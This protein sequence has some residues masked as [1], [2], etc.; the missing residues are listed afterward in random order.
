MTNE[1]SKTIINNHIIDIDFFQKFSNKTTKL[2]NNENRDFSIDGR[3]R[4]YEYEFIEPVYITNIKIE[5]EGY[6]S[7]D[8]F[9]IEIHHVDGTKHQQKVRV[10][11][12]IVSL[13]L[14]KLVNA[15]RFRPDSKILSKTSIVRVVATGLGP[16]DKRDSQ[17]S[18][19]LIQECF[20]G[21][22]L[23][24]RRSDKR[25]MGHHRTA[26]AVRARTLGTT[27]PGQPS[28]SQRH[29]ACFAGRLP[30]ARHA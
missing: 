28:F 30:V 20:S 2:I 25:G 9:E 4:W 15:F 6:S 29:A 5:S 3:H 22:I 8:D 21:G 14:G 7:F 27:G 18:V 26:F 23:G 11:E 17:F 12:N 13:K 16:V 1:D 19:V 24:A 10:S